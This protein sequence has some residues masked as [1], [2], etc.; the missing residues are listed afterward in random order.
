MSSII[1]ASGS[2]GMLLG[3]MTYDSTE[4]HSAVTAK[5]SSKEAADAAVAELKRRWETLLTGGKV[6]GC[7]TFSLVTS[8][9]RDVLGE[10]PPY[11]D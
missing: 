6:P 9:S 4:S 10:W 2:A 3:A 11:I 8:T 7:S 5:F 1:E